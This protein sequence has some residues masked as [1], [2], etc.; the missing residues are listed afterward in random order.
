MKRI[1]GGGFGGSGGVWLVE[2]PSRKRGSKNP[3]HQTHKDG[4]QALTW[5]SSIPLSGRMCGRVRMH[6]RLRMRVR[7]LPGRLR[8]GLCS[9]LRL[10]CPLD[11]LSGAEAVPGASWQAGSCGSNSCQK[12]GSVPAPPTPFLPSPSR[13]GA[14]L[15]AS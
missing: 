13:T 12:P 14:C 15:Q 1:V 6:M 8:G 5:G 3:Y 10:S 9:R 7:F 11:V 2:H 4:G